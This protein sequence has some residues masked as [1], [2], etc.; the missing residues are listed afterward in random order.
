MPTTTKRDR[1]EEYRR[2]DR[3]HEYRRHWLPATKAEFA[4]R[5]EA[6][7]ALPDVRTVTFCPC[8]S[9]TIRGPIYSAWRH[10]VMHWH[11]L[12]CACAAEWVNRG[13]RI[14][15]RWHR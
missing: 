3:T 14:V 12:C 6:D 15:L 13:G 8:C 11:F 2:R 4:Q 1:R 9:D 10:D 5:M 7:I